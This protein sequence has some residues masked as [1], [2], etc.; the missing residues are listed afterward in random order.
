MSADKS[1]VDCVV[2]NDLNTIKEKVESMAA[3]AIMDRVAEKKA[4][5]ID[6][7]NKG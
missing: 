6:R 5:V 7:I 2:S 3:Q 1:F 4:V